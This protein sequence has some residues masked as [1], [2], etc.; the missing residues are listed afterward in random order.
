MPQEK[1]SPALGKSP[2]EE[3]RQSF[4]ECNR[5][6]AIAKFTEWNSMFV[7]PSPSPISNIVSHHYQIGCQCVDYVLT[8]MIWYFSFQENLPP[9]LEA[10]AER[11]MAKKRRGKFPEELRNFALTVNFY[12]PKAYMYLRQKWNCLPAMSTIKSGNLSIFR[13]HWIE[14]HI[15]M[16]GRML[17][18]F[19]VFFSRV[20]T[21][22]LIFFRLGALF[23]QGM[24]KINFIQQDYRSH[25]MWVCSSIFLSWITS[26]SLSFNH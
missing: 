17:F 15:K 16:H 11:F 19:I 8:I 24:R 9:S 7:H 3:N 10:I 21:V 4:E 12:S 26:S 23:R 5:R 22:Y 13:N 1:R 25:M 14:I 2:T 18:E 6:D 20:H